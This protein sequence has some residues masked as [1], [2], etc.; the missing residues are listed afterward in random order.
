MQCK[1]TKRELIETIYVCSRCGRQA[2]AADAFGNWL[3]AKRRG[4]T[5]LIIRCPDCKTKYAV[6]QAEK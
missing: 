1:N 2:K 6:R 3:I 4:K 5:T